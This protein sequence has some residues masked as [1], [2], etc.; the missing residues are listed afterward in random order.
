[1]KSR[2]SKKNKR[3]L[4][5]LG[6]VA[7]FVAAFLTLLPI[8]LRV[9]VSKWLTDQGVAT[10]IEDIDLNLFT[11]RLAIK[12]AH[13]ETAQGDGFKIDHALVNVSYGALFSKQIYISNLELRDSRIDVRI[14]ES[15]KLFVAGLAI[16]PSEEEPPED[17]EQSSP[18]G[19]GIERAA[20]GALTLRY[21]QPEFAREITLSSSSTSDLATWEPNQPFP[22]DAALS[23]GDS[24]INLGGQLRPFGERIRGEITLGIKDFDLDLVAPLAKQA[25]VT[26]LAGVIN[27]DLNILLDYHADEGLQL[28]V[29]GD[30]MVNGTRVRMSD[31]R[32]DN[33][34]VTWKGTIQAKLLQSEAANDQV[35]TDGHL[36][37][38]KVGFALPGTLAF[39]QKS[40]AWQGK[41]NA[42][43]GTPL[44]IDA[45]GELKLSQTHLDLFESGKSPADAAPIP[46]DAPN[47]DEPTTAVNIAE[48][49]NSESSQANTI[50]AEQATDPAPQA[51]PD[52][53]PDF[54]A[55]SKSETVTPEPAPQATDTEA[56]AENAP[57]DDDK[58]VTQA[59]SD[60]LAPQEQTENEQPIAEQIQKAPRPSNAAKTLV[61]DQGETRWKGKISTRLGDQTNINANGNLSLQKTQLDMPGQLQ[62]AQDSLNWNGD[63]KTELNEQ[64]VQINTQSKIK[65]KNT[66]LDIPEQLKLAQETLD[67]DGKLKTKLDDQGAHVETQSTLKTKNTKLDLIGNGINLAQRALSWEGSADYGPGEPA[68]AHA[69]GT[70]QADGLDLKLAPQNMAILAEN[71]GWTG[72]VAL[73]PQAEGLPEQ[74]ELPLKL[75]GQVTAGGLLITDT[76][77]S[78]A[79]AKVGDVAINDITIT[80]LD[81]IRSGSVKV[82]AIAALERNAA[83]P[84]LEAFPYIA[85]V[86][87]VAVDNLAYTGQSRLALGSLTILGIDALLYRGPKET[88]W[89]AA[90]W[91]GAEPSE[92]PAA[93][94]TE[95]ATTADAAEE[96]SQSSFEIALGSG[97]I[98]ESKLT[99]DDRGVSPAF[100]TDLSKLRITLADLDSAKPAQGSA[101]DI[102]SALGRYGSIQAGGII[103]PFLE[104]PSAD[105]TGKI[106]AV[107]L[108]PI[109]GYTSQAIDRRIDQGTFS[110]DLRLKLDRGNIDANADLTLTKLRIG[111]AQSE[112][113]IVQNR[114][115]LPLNK[116]LSL[117]RDGDGNITLDLPVGGN[118]ENPEFSVLKIVRDAV[119]KSL[120]KAVL[121]IYSPLKL[122]KGLIDLATALRLDP[123]L[124]PPGKVELD[125]TDR[126]FLD[127]VAK[128][129]TDRPKT[130]LIVCGHAVPTD[131][132]ALNLPDPDAILAEG[133]NPPT[134]EQLSDARDALFKLASERT[135]LVGDYLV[136]KDIASTRLVLC[137]PALGEPAR[138]LPRTSLSY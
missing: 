58:S 102:F 32:L 36:T 27:T 99:I 44:G 31:L 138:A 49:S 135:S 124:Y 105:V 115:G 91:F 118:L 34:D 4:I 65:T 45:D 28:G 125:D 133:E 114:L 116:I 9:G 2:L 30:A 112:S 88:G 35:M 78:K 3:R 111:G 94:A 18:W 5:I 132:T 129:L 104:P 29:D 23:I 85:S 66:T 50:Q 22:L 12:N 84:R 10:Q 127:K 72:N 61:L 53:E 33:A 86:G 56:V 117:L 71:L 40:T 137:N 59:D 48:D 67:W 108:S 14:D 134:P 68:L 42:Q 46:A 24:Q 52:S 51:S 38:D 120:R 64:G 21:A 13:G 74:S 113:G 122:G 83:A 20:I 43:L 11:G 128:R 77:L 121:V 47:A 110:A 96:E 97:Q 119:F 109:S 95:T 54:V 63:L 106:N 73:D 75:T 62:L 19:F 87:S 57:P 107:N 70:L 81:D 60:K 82:S 69:D 100:E 98:V 103:N 123:V 93:Q 130:E 16:E 136:S 90:Q 131:R 80:G 76:A 41:I 37:V 92:P 26:D 55:D 89:E 101:L 6:V 8:G 25:G 79:L 7:T 1:M 39:K 17:E 15:D 126:T